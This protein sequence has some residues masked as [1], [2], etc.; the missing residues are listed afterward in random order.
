M[1][2]PDDLEPYPE[3]SLERVAL[4]IGGGSSAAQAL[5]KMAEERAKGNRVWCE[6]SRS[7]RMFAVRSESPDLSQVGEK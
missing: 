7:A 6:Y 3:E 1:R 4:I 2:E 5:R